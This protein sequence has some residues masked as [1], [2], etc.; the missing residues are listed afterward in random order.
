MFAAVVN[1]YRDTLLTGW[2][3]W[4]ATSR[5]GE[6]DS[7]A[8]WMLTR[9]VILMIGGLLLALIDIYALAWCCHMLAV[10]VSLQARRALARTGT[11]MMCNADSHD[12]DGD[13]ARRRPSAS[14][15]RGGGKPAVSKM[16]APPTADAADTTA[17][18]WRGGL[19]A[20]GAFAQIVARVPLDAIDCAC[21]RGLGAY[22]EVSCFGVYWGD[23]FIY[24]CIHI[25]P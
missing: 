24:L 18:G 19:R 13:A 14:L 3:P 4:F 5:S 9:N 7:L 15:E 8:L 1:L 11:A 22:F 12:S 10:D 16:G 23:L 17:V 20:C 6:R 21:P 25:R 2:D